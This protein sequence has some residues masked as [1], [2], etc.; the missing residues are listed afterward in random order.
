MEY[1]ELNQLIKT[2]HDLQGDIKKLETLQDEAKARISKA[3]KDANITKYQ[4]GNLMASLT[5][6]TRRSINIKEAEVLLDKDTFNKLAK[7]IPIT[8]LRVIDTT[9]EEKLSNG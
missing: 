2:Y 4:T 9:K 6:S 8:T 5:Q 7:V 3:L 1:Q